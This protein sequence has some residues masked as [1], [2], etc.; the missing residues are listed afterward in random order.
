MR[1]HNLSL[2]NIGPFNEANVEFIKEDDDILKPPVIIITGENGTGK[3]IILDAIRALC[4]GGYYFIERDITDTD[5]FEIKAIIGLK[6][7]VFDLASNKK[8][9][10]VLKM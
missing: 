1:I 8:N 5:D 7:N 3:S 6:N 9:M 4:L 2:K 10:V